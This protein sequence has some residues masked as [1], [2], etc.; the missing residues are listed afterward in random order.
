MNPTPNPNPTRD[1]TLWQD[2]RALPGQYWILFSGTL[3]NRFGHFVIPFMAIYLRQQGHD[4][5]TTGLVMAAYG[6]GALCAGAIGGYLA[7]RLGRKPT[8]LISCAGAALF[9]MVLSQ[10]HGVPA[11]VSATFMTGLLT[12]MYGPAAG[13]L[14][15]DLIPPELRVRA[16]ACQRLAINFGFAAGMATAGFM[17]KQS[18]MALFIADAATTII[19]GLTVLFGLKP[20]PL[21]ATPVKGGWTH[22]LKHMRGNAP[23]MLATGAS[24]LIG[25]V[26]WQ[27]SSSY[28]LQTTEGAGL[29]ERAYGLLM[30]LN[31]ILIVFLELPLT[32]YTRR[33]HPVHAMAAGYAVIGLG[34]GLNAFGASLPLLVI[35]MVVFTAGEMV[36]LPVANSY[37]AGL[38]PD[39]MR[40]RYQG[41]SSISWSTATMIGP[42]LGIAMWQF[43]PATLWIATLVASATA[44]IL[45]LATRRL[46]EEG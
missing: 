25:I 20:R 26:F 42:S 16:F 15:A 4:V 34:M 43:N 39:E 21:T 11:L 3:V 36:A 22:A 9:M 12:A 18:F 2:L 13:A 28:G 40:G 41:V 37:I 38:A 46:A 31:G 23:F 10:A 7:D 44:A 35:S 1:T 32:S 24:L 27:M 45:M 29:D 14:I 6:A 30:A 33:F 17:A 19:L 5:K 8:M